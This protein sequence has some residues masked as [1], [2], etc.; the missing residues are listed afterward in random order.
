MTDSKSTTVFR[1]KGLIRKNM[2]FPGDVFIDGDLKSS[3]LLLIGGNLT[4]SGACH[5][6]ELICLGNVTV[7]GNLS[8]GDIRIRGVLSC[9]GNLEVFDLFLTDDLQEVRYWDGATRSE[10]AVLAFG[11]ARSEWYSENYIFESECSVVVG[12]WFDVDD[13]DI[14]GNVSIK[15][16]AFNVDGQIHGHLECGG[17]ISGESLQAFGHCDVVHAINLL[18]KLVAAQLTCGRSCVAGSIRVELDFHAGQAIVSDENIEVGGHL[19]SGNRIQARG[20][21]QA[22]RSVQSASSI[23]SPKGVQA[24]RSYGIYAG[25]DV[26]REHKEAHGFIACRTR[27]DGIKSGVHVNGKRFKQLNERQLVSW[28]ASDGSDGL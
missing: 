5:L 18:G 25:L 23:F 2:T 1:A 10:Q 16:D 6:N 26:S 19:K 7:E 3:G 4:V 21:V 13:I 12:G 17:S 11:E 20:F 8:C 15:G 24:G 28:P 22:G 9:K 27:P 14:H